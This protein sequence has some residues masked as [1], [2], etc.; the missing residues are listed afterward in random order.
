MPGYITVTSRRAGRLLAGFAAATVLG[1]AVYTAVVQAE[2]ALRLYDGY[3]MLGGAAVAVGGVA[4]VV[5]RWGRERALVAV[6]AAAALGAWLPLVVLA[7]RARIPVAARLKG[8][9]FLSS[10]DVIG[11]ALPVGI[12]LAWLALREH[13]PD[14]PKLPG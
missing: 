4:P 1:I 10:A 14:D 12:A 7:W 8:A 11:V 6:S 13:R 5:W 2:P 9:V 3:W